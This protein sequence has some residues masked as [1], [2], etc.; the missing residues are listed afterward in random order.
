V[1]ERLIIAPEQ[2]SS[3][4]EEGTGVYG[5]EGAPITPTSSNV[6]VFYWK[7]TGRVMF[8]RSVLGTPATH[9]FSKIRDRW[10]EFV[11]AA[12]R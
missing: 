1:L 2:Y 5:P 4:Q 7:K 12:G 3:F 9:W 11:A 10:G 8:L 6:L